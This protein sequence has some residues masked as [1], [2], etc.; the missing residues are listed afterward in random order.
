MI[1]YP[2]ESLDVTNRITENPLIKNIKLQLIKQQNS[3]R[4]SK[5]K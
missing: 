1:S 2:P 5:T 4:K 3:F